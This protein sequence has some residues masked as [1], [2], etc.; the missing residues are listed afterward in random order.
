MSLLS[1]IKMFGSLQTIL[2]L[3]RVVRLRSEKDKAKQYY[4]TSQP[5]EMMKREKNQQHRISRS[6]DRYKNR[7]HFWIFFCGQDIRYLLDE[8]M[9]VYHCEYWCQSP[10]EIDRRPFKLFP[11]SMLT[12]ILL[13]L[14]CFLHSHSQRILGKQ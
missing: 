12:N 3:R 1:L 10:W 9:Y 7:S 5:D 2:I 6:N 14:L 4:W 8:K 13:C 11:F